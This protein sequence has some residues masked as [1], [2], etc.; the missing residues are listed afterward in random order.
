MPRKRKPAYTLHKP[1][2]QARVRIKGKDFYLGEFGSPESR[3][4]Y[5]DQIAEW[6]RGRDLS[7]SNITIDE[8]ALKFL[9]FAD[10]YYRHAD[11]KVTGTAD[12][13]R[14]AMRPLV[15][16][17]GHSRVRDFGPKKLKEVRQHV[18]EKGHCRRGVNLIV[19]R[20]RQ[21]FKWGASEELVPPS[22]Y[23][24]LTAVSGLRAGRTKAKES[25]PI[26]PVNDDVVD[27]T[28]EHL[29][30]VVRDMV[31]IQRLSGCRPSEVCMMRPCDIDRDSSVWR[32]VPEHHKTEHHGKKRVVMLGP[33]S[34][35]ILMPYLLRAEA[36]YCFS[37]ADARR[38]QLEARHERRKVPMN[39]GNRPGSNKQT[40]PKRTPGNKYNKDSYARAI[41]RACKKAFPAPEGLLE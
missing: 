32:Y 19:Q 29:S 24:S 25:E 33:K 10:G 14:L 37:P 12:N 22:V 30:S 4:N 5:D 18:I 41:A 28:I 26:R 36:D 35:K 1:T 31:H 17:F 2:G 3:D 20:I 34:Q 23:Q 7:A 15:K 39:C 11:G 16:L 13:L 8:L 9:D 6:Q 21:A 38:K 27:A 40:K